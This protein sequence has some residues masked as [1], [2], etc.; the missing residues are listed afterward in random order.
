MIW[1]MFN[2]LSLCKG[3]NC[4][5]CTLARDFRLK[6]LLV[7]RF[8]VACAM[9]NSFESY[10]SIFVILPGLPHLLARPEVIVGGLTG[11]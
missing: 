5:N 11:L 7:N 6:F 4:Y 1:H 8:M 3:A 10:L 2:L 9:L